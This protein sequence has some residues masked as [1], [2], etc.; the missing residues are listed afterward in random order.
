MEDNG[1]CYAEI[2]KAVYGLKESWYLANV[3]LKQILAKEG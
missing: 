3:E 1:W 2:R